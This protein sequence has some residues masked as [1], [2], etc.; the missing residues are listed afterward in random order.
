MFAQFFGS[1]LLNNKIVTPEQL[2]EA[3]AKLKESHIKLGTLAMHQGLM[4]A[5]EV[6]EVCYLQ[7]REDKR[8]GEIAI[9]R[10]YLTDDQVEDLL[11]SQNPD[12]LLLG[13]NLVDMGIISNEQLQDVLLDYQN[14]T[15]IYDMDIENQAHFDQLV[16]KFLLVSENALDDYAKAYLKLLFNDFVRFIGEDF[17]PMAPVPATEY[18]INYCVEQRISGDIEAIT[19]LDMPKST[20]IA[21]ASR[22]ASMEFE[23]FNEYVKASIEDFLNLHNGL[24]GV[25]ISNSHSVEL[26]LEPPTT[27]EE[28]ILELETN[29][30][31]IPFIYPFGTL[32]LIVTF[33]KES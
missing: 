30:Y 27:V 28:D 10:D 23:E 33:H 25:N 2:S 5:A 22:Y 8:F 19:Y 6:D 13:Q 12:Y 17:I 3:I 1:Y 11:H 9:E 21:F 32:H 14:D 31:V 7:S 20:A 16:K 4:T 26:A 29:S 24:Y 15:E 18:P